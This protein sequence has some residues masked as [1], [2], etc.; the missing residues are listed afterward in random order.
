MC[1]RS[2][3]HLQVLACSWGSGNLGK[4]GHII[5]SLCA[6]SCIICVPACYGLMCVAAS[7]CPCTCWCEVVISLH[8]CRGSWKVLKCIIIRLW[9]SANRIATEAHAI[10]CHQALVQQG[11][12]TIA[13]DGKL[14]LLTFTGSCIY[15][16]DHATDPTD[17][18]ED[19]CQ[20]STL[21]PEVL[22][23]AHIH[24]DVRG[25]FRASQL[26]QCLPGIL[27]A[28]APIPV[29]PACKGNAMSAVF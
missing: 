14:Y 2:S 20:V 3:Q 7:V 27:I 19:T 26:S 8:A 28:R 21:P 12:V 10:P 6:K 17:T 24:V 25:A 15:T 13:F 9:S 16:S 22:G 29:L 18:I 23:Q 5:N 11:H 1:R 4:E